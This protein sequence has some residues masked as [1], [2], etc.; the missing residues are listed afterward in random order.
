MKKINSLTFILAM[1]LILSF[2]PGCN[3]KTDVSIESQASESDV[4][5]SDIIS[6]DDVVSAIIKQSSEESIGIE[7]E[8]SDPGET[9]S[10]EG[11]KNSVASSS[12]ASKA[13]PTAMPTITTDP[14]DLEAKLPVLDIK[15]KNV[16]ICIDWAPNSSWVVAWGKAFEACYPG[17]KVTYK[18]ATPAVKASKLAVWKSSKTSP[19][20]IYIK[21][22]ESWPN[23]V[24]LD[25]VEPVDNMIN[26]NA[27]FWGTIKDTMEGLKINNKTYAIVV[28]KDIYGSVIYK[29]SV[30]QNAGLRDPIDLFFEDKWTW[31]VFEDYA[32]K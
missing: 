3:G 24:N 23:L 8:D 4:E 21:P 6:E 30:L 20:A 28:N 32:K 29:K 26:I 18:I 9:E 25:L 31:D 2:L 16:T 14:S 7:S 27:P 5:S 22:E 19:D 10:S 1:S 13:K 11:D 17:I 15:N 12:T